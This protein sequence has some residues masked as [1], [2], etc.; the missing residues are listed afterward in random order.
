[1]ELR[2]ESGY[3][4]ILNKNFKRCFP[5]HKAMG[6]KVEKES[7][8]DAGNRA[9]LRSPL[10]CVS[11]DHFG[12]MWLCSISSAVNEIQDNWGDLLSSVPNISLKYRPWTLTPSFLKRF[13]NLP[14]GTSLLFSILAFSFSDSSSFSSS[15]N[16]TVI[17]K[18]TF[19]LTS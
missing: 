19:L 10:D 3:C 15:Q 12:R 6:H 14:S 1:M 11:L 2:K 8:M 13:L 17:H 9:A 18:W 4:V 7:P 5:C 16:I